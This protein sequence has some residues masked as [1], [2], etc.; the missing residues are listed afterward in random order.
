MGRRFFGTIIKRGKRYL[1]QYRHKGRQYYTQTRDTKRQVEVDLMRV[2]A[3]IEDNRWSPGLRQGAGQGHTG[4][5]LTLSQWRDE[6]LNFLESGGYSPGTLRSYSSIWRA[7]VLPFFGEGAFLSEIDTAGVERFIARLQVSHSPTTVTNVMRALRAGL[8]AAHKRHPEIVVPTFP[9]R[10]ANRKMRAEATTWTGEQLRSIIECAEDYYRAAIALAAYGALRSGEIAALDRSDIDL[11]RV[12]VDA[13]TKRTPGGMT[14]IGEPKSKAAYR[15]NVLPS[16]A[17]QIVEHHLEAYVPPAKEAL[18]YTS[19]KSVEG[20]PV[21][22]R[23]FRYAL[24]QACQKAGLPDG[25]FHDL[26]H[27]SL[28]LYGQAGA[29]LAEL[30]AR[31]GHTDVQAVMIYQHASIERDAALAERM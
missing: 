23:S 30:M 29:T 9:A 25:R 7:H 19:R 15:T 20:G 3:A 8:R 13:S 5:N 18:L 21:D 11:P 17:V 27:S 26:R 31:A 2:K 12:R 1:G 24:S 16:Y 22:G 14:V 10:I 4:E 6:W 28:T